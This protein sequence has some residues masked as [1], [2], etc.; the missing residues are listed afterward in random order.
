MA[1]FVVAL[2][3]HGII[4]AMDV[5]INHE[6]I[7]RLPGK[8]GAEA[9]QRLHSAREF[10]FGAIFLTL[11]WC[12]WHGAFALVIVAL[13]LV[14]ILISVFDTVLELDTRLLPV[15]E[16]VLHLALFVNLGIILGLLGPTLVAW[17]Q[18]PTEL[19]RVE[20]GWMS[21][22]LSALALLAF[23]WSVRDWRGQTPV[24]PLGV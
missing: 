2:I 18:M 16:R 14:E 22:G 5:L 9:E 19:V 23:I 12:E 21:W 7:A 15:P 3:A 1:P 10:V 17:A 8:S 4:G 6:L 13:F 24:V 11:A 20:Y